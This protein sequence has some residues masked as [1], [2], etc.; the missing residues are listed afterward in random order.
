R[1]LTRAGCL[2]SIGHTTANEAEFDAV[3]A[4]GARLTTHVFN[5]M[6]G[7]HH[8]SPGVAAFAL[9]NDAVSASLIADGIHV[10]PRVLRLGF[11]MLGSE[12]VV[13]VT[14][15]IGWGAPSIGDARFVL[16]DG[17]PRLPDGTLA[18]SVLTMDRAIRVCVAAGIDLAAALRAASTNPARLLGLNDRGVIAVSR[19]ADLVALTPELQIEEVWIAGSAS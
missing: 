13:L 8:R 11:A 17:A 15:A 16:R 18:G 19:R 7:I 14:D 6:S 5:G 9:T 3:V 1:L 2:V 12:R 10:H 4:A